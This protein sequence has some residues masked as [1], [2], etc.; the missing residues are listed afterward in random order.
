MC[1]GGRKDP[2]V[3]FLPKISE[4]RLGRWCMPVTDTLDILS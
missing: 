3:F 4:M 1:D 2:D